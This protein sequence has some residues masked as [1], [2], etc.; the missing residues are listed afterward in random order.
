LIGCVRSAVG[1]VTRSRAW[2]AG[3]ATSSGRLQSELQSQLY[4]LLTALQAL[5]SPELRAGVPAELLAGMQ[6][7]LRSDH[8]QA[9]PLLAGVQLVWLVL[10]Q[11]V[12]VAAR[13]GEE[14]AV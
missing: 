8:V 1:F 3:R 10:K 13:I 4:P 5:L 2:S 9:A 11:M 7:H 6:P 12:Q 14:A